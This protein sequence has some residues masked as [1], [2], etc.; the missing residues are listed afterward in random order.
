MAAIAVV[1]ASPAWPVD[2]MRSAVTHTRLFTRRDARRRRL[3]WVGAL[4]LAVV[5]AAVLVGVGV[6][7]GAAPVGAQA[8]ANTLSSIRVRDNAYSSGPAAYRY[9][10]IAPAFEPGTNAYTVTVPNAVD[11][12][13]IEVER[14]RS[15]TD[16][17][18]PSSTVGAQSVSVGSNAFTVGV[19]P[20]PGSGLVNNV[21]TVTVTRS[22]ANFDYD[23]DDDGLIDVRTLAQLNA[24]RYDLDGDGTAAL[25]GT[26]DSG[27][28]AAYDRAFWYPEAGLGCQGVDDDDDADTADV[29]VCRGYELRADLDFDTDGDGATYTLAADGTVSGDSG[30][31]Y[32]NGGAGWTPIADAGIG[33]TDFVATFEGNGHTIS[34]LFVNGGR[35]QS[36]ALGLFGY[37]G[38]S[39]ANARIRNLGLV[40]VF[41]KG[42]ATYTGGLAG[43]LNSNQTIGFGQSA[44]TAYG[45]I[46][47]SYVT[48]I[49][50]GAGNVGGLV[51]Q[52]EGSIRASYS[53]AAV[54][55]MAQAGG[56]VGQVGGGIIYNSY[57]AGP[58]AAATN[59]GGLAGFSSLNF[60]TPHGN[61]NVRSSYWDLE[62][63]CEHTRRA[64][65]SDHLIYGRGQTTAGLTTPTGYSGIYAAWDDLDVNDDGSDDDA[66]SF[67]A[68]RYPVLKIGGHDASAQADAQRIDYDCDDDGLIEI[69]RLAQLDVMRYDRDGSGAVDDGANSSSYAA[70]YPIAVAGMG[71]RLVGATNPAPVC[72]GYELG[73]NSDSVVALNFDTDGDDDVDASDSGGRYWNGGLGWEPIASTSTP[74][75]GTF[76]G[77]S[78]PVNRLF[79]NRSGAAGDYVGLFAAVGAGPSWLGGIRQEARLEG[80]RLVNASVTGR[81]YVGGLV[82]SGIGA[83]ADSS[84]SGAVSGGDYV[85]GLAG[86]VAGS[87]VNSYGGGSVS[88]VN[89]VGGLVGILGAGGSIAAAYAGSTV[90]GTDKV[91]GLAG[92]NQG[93]IAASY[94]MGAVTGATDVGGLAGAKSL[95]GAATDAYFDVETT[96]QAASPG[97]GIAQSTRALMEPTAYGTAPSIYREWDV[98]IDG[99][100]G[101]D[102]P[103]DFGTNRQYPVLK[104]GGHDTAG[105]FAL[106]PALPTD[107]A[108]SGLAVTDGDGGV[109]L[110]PAFSPDTLAYAA[111]VVATSSR[112]TVAAVARRSLAAVGYSVSDADGSTPDTFE[113]DLATGVNTFTITVT[114]AGGTPPAT[115]EYTLTITRAAGLAYSISSPAAGTALD[116]DGDAAART[117]T[118]GVSGNRAPPAAGDVLC[119]IAPNTAGGRAGTDASDFASLTAT[120]SFTASGAATDT[121]GSCVFTVSDDSDVESAEYFTVTLSAPAAN[122][123]AGA[124]YGAGRSFSIAASDALPDDATLSSLS[125]VNASTTAAVVLAPAFSAARTAYTAEVENGVTQVTV[126]ATSTDAIAGVAYEPAVDA[127]ATAPGHQVNVAVGG[128][129]IKAVVTAADG[130][131]AQEYVVALFRQGAGNTLRHLRVIGSDGNTY[132]LTPVFNPDTDT[133]DAAVPRRVSSVTIYAEGTNRGAGVQVDLN[134]VGADRTSDPIA[135]AI[136]ARKLIRIQ[137]TGAVGDGNKSYS[138]YVTRSSGIDYD[139]DDDGLID[140][141]NLAQLNAMR[142]DLD[143]DGTA[144]LSFSGDNDFAATYAG[145]FPSPLAGMGCRLADHD[146]DTTTAEQPTCRGYELRADLDFDTDDDGATWSRAADGT[147]TG[148]SGDAWYNGGAGWTPIGDVD[149]SLNPFITTFEGNGHTIS[150]LF[151]NEARSTSDAVGLFGFVG[152]LD[153][154]ARIRNVGLV[155]VLV[156]ETNAA[157]TGGLAGVLISEHTGSVSAAGFNIYGEI[158]ASYV[159]GSVSGAD[160]VGGLVGHSDGSIRASYSHAAVTGGDAVGGLVGQNGN[161]IV[162]NSYATGPVTGSSRA[163]GLTGHSTLNSQSPHQPSNVRNSYWDLRTSCQHTRHTGSEGSRT[164]GRGKTTAELTTLTGYTGIYA[165]W[166]ELD[167]N[168]DGSSDAA[169]QF[170][171]GRYPTLKIGG[172]DASAQASAQ[173]IDYDCDDDGLIEI[174]SLAGLNVTRYDLDGSGA[175]DSSA[176]AAAYAGQF[177]IAAATMGCALADHDG[178]AAT[179]PVRVCRGYELGANASASSTLLSLDFD[180]DGSGG[181]NAGD[182]YWNGGAGWTPIG[183][184]AQPWAAVFRGNQH[185]LSNLYI[186]RAAADTGLFGVVGASGRLEGV[187]L[188]DV[189][190]TSTMDDTGGLAG[191]N[192]GVISASGVTGTVSGG[193]N[194]GGL[195]GFGTGSIVGSYAKADVSGTV[196]V[197]GIVGASSGPVTAAYALGAVSGTRNVGGIAGSVTGDITASYA[198]GAVSGSSGVGALLGN[199]GGS[200]VITNGYYDSEIAGAMAGAGGTGYTRR[201]LQQPVA[202]RSGASV[203]ERIYVGWDVDLDNADG[204][205]NA[206]TG[207]DDPWDFGTNQQY[208]VLQY[209]GM[210]VAAQ[211]ALQPPLAGDTRLGSLVIT[212]TTSALTPAFDAG[213]TTY[214]LSPNPGS[215]YVTVAASPALSVTGVSIHPDDGQDGVPGHQVNLTRGVNTITV[216][217]TAQNRAGARYTVRF[218][219]AAAVDYDD[220]DDGLIDVRTLAQLDAIRYDRNGDGKRGAASALDWAKYTAAYPLAAAGMGCRRVD[221]DGAGPTPPAPVCTGYELRRGLDFDT[222]EA[223]VRTDDAYYNDGAGWT[224]IGGAAAAFTGAFQG[225]G[226]TIANLHINATGVGAVGLFGAAVNGTIEGVH[227]TGVDITASYTSSGQT[228]YDAGSLVGVMRGVTVRASSAVGTITATASGNAV[229]SV[230]GLAGRSISGA[231]G[232]SGS[233]IEASYAAVDVTLSSTSTANPTLNPDTAGGLVGTFS[234][235]SARPSFVTAAYALGDVAANRSGSLV[236]GLIGEGAGTVTASYATGTVT[237]STAAT[238]GLIGD[239]GS[240]TTVTASYWDSITSGVADDA[241]DPATAPEGKT[242]YELRTPT[243]YGTATSTP[244]SIY[245]GWDVDVDGETGGDDPWDFGTNQQYPVLKYGGH[246]VSAQFLLQPTIPSDNTLAALSVAPAVL[247]PGL[248]AATTTYA[249]IL[250][251]EA[252]AAVVTL[253]YTLNDAAA[254]STVSAIPGGGDAVTADADEDAAGYQVSV[255]AARTVITIAVTAP[256][257]AVREYAVTV[258]HAAAADYDRDDNGLIDVRTLAQLDAIRY[259]LDGD[260]RPNSGDWAPYTAAY[261]R[262]VPGMGCPSDTCTGYELVNA[263]DFD[264]GEAGDRTDDAY[265]NDGAGW[266]PI[267]HTQHS[268]Y[269]GDFQGNGHTIA[270]LYI[271]ST[272]LA[273]VGLFGRALH[274]NVSGLIEGVHLTGVDITASYTDNRVFPYH[275]VGALVG[276]IS[277]TVRGSSAVGEITTTAGGLVVSRV[278]GLVGI[279]FDGSVIANNYAAVDVTVSSTATATLV[280]RAGGL[281]GIVQGSPARS[282]ITASYALGDVAIN[283]AGARVGGLV[284]EI[285]SADVSASYATGTATGSTAATRGLT[286]HITGTNTPIIT[287]SYWDTTASGVADD[288]DDPAVAPEGKTVDE[289][290]TPTAYGTSTTTDIYVNWDVDVD[291]VAGVDDPWDF[292][293]AEQ[294]PVLQQGGHSIAAQHALQN[295]IAYDGDG[296]GLIDVATLAQLDAIRYDL[297]GDGKQGS[298]S[299]ADWAKYAAA[300]PRALPGMGC[301]SYTCT[302]YELVN[303]LDFDTGEAGVRTD[304]AYYND[305]AGW[306]P[307]G[308]SGLTGA[309]IG[310]FRGNGYAI[311]NLYINSS[312]VLGVGLFGGMID[313][314]IEGVHLTGVD[315]TTNYSSG[316]LIIHDVGGLAGSA[317]GTVRG[318]SVTGQIRTNAGGMAVSL[319]G[320]MVGSAV[321][322]SVFAN[323]YASVDV[324]VTSTS[325]ATLADQVGGLAGLLDG[326]LGRS[327]MTASYALGDVTASRAGARVGGLIGNMAIADVSA[328]YALGTVTGA[329]GATRGLIGGTGTNTAVTASYWDTSTTGVADDGDTAAPEGK[330]T[331]ELR[332]PTAYGVAT[333][334]PPSIYAGW[335][336]DVDGETGGDDPW[337]FGTNLEYP[338]LQFGGHDVAAQRALL[339]EVSTD[340]SLLALSVGPAVLSPSFTAATTT[341]AAMVPAESS[342]TAVLL[343]YTLGD[344]NASAAVSAQGPVGA[345]VTADADAHTPG[346]QVALSAAGD[347]VITIAVTAQDGSAGSYTVTVMAGAADYDDDE[348]GLIDVRTLAQ[349]DAIRY[350]LNGD[351]AVDSSANNAAYAAAFPRAASGMGC[352][353]EIDNHGMR[354]PPTCTGY[355]LRGSLLFNTGDAGIR[356]DDQYYNGGAGWT[357]IGTRAAPYTATFRGNGYR[358]ADLYINSNGVGWVGLFGVLDG[359]VIEGLGLVG[360]DITATHANS[361]TVTFLDVGAV[362]GRIAGGGTVRASSA[363]GVI[364]THASGSQLVSTAGGLV[365]TVFLD[366][367]VANSYA[368]VDVTVNSTGTITFPD[369]AGG[370]IGLMGGVQATRPTLTAGYATGAVKVSRGLAYAGGLVGS[371]HNGRVSASYATGRAADANG[372]AQPLIGAIQTRARISDSYWDSIASGAAD[373][374]DTTAPEGKT[375]AVLQG[376]TGY[377]TSTTT[378]IYVNWNVDV[379][380]ARGADDPWDFGTDQQYPVLQTGGHSIAA[381]RALLRRTTA[382]DGDGD[383]LIDVTSLA[384]LDAIRYDLNG[385]GRADRIA[386]IGAYAAGYPDAIPGMGCPSYTCTGYELVNGLDFDTGEAGDRTDD[387]YYRGGEGWRPIAGG[388][389][390]YYNAPA[391]RYSG[392]FNG[393]GHAIANLHIDVLLTGDANGNGA[394]AGLFGYVT[395]RVEQVALVNPEVKAVST[396]GAIAGRLG[397]GGSIVASYVQGGEI[398]GWNWLGGLV[399]VNNGTITASYTDVRVNSSS[400]T[401]PSRN[402]GAAGGLAGWNTGTIT[403]SYAMGSVERQEGAAVTAVTGGLTALGSVTGSEVVTDSYWDTIRT[404][405]STSRTAPA[406]AGKTTYELRTPTTYGASTTTDIYAGWNV[407]V[408]GVTGPD[409]PWNF[410]TNL[411]YPV[412]KYGGHDTAAQFGRQP[413]IASDNTLSALSVAP[414]VLSPSFAAGRT[415][416]TAALPVGSAA[417]AVTLAYTQNDAASSTAAV[418]AVAAGGAAVTADADA[419]APGYQVSVPARTVITIAVSTPDGAVRRYT[420]TIA[421]SA[422]ENDY[423]GNDNGLIDVRTLAQL[424]AIRY[425]LDGDGRASAGDLANYLAAFPNPV[426][427][428]GCPSGGCTGYELLNSLDFDTGEAGD[429]TDDAYYNDGAGWTPIAHTQH[430]AYIGDFQGNGHTIA[431]LYINS[432]GLA[433]VGLFGRALH[434]NVSGLIEG[435]HLTGVD[436]TASYTDNRVFPYHD[437]GALVGYISGTV[438][439]SSAVGEIRTTAGGQVVSRVGGLVGIAFDGSVIANNYAAVDVTVSSTATATLVDRAGGLVGIVQ[440]SPARSTITASYALGDVAINRAGARVGG[441]VGEISTSDVT[442]SY[443]TGTVTGSTAAT[444]GLTGHTAGTNP[445]VAD[446]YWDTTA[447]GVADDADDPAVAPEGKSIDELRAPTDYG[448]STTTDIYVNWNVDVDGVAGVD[449][450][451][452]FG[453]AEQYPVLKRGGHSIAAQ[454]ALQNVT[455][456][457]GDG[458]GLIDVATLAQLDAIRYDLNGDG[459]VADADEA[460]YAV[461]YPRA[462]VGMGCPSYT[463]TG[464]ELVNGLD[465]DTGEAGDRTDDAYYNDGAGW[466]PIGTVGAEY[467]ATFRGNGYGNAIAN[468]DIN[469]TGWGEAGLFGALSDGVIEGVHLTG[470]DIGASRTS[471]STQTY[472]RAGALSSYVARSTV[473]GSSAAGAITTTAGG[474]VISRVGGLVG[475]VTSSSSIVGSYA[476]VDVTVNSTTP[477]SSNIGDSDSAGGLAASL[478]GTASTRS[479]MTAVYATGDVAANRGGTFVGGLIGVAFQASVTAG[480]ATGTVTGPTTARTQG[481][482]NRLGTTATITDS[483]WDTSTTGVADDGDATA[484]EG[485]PTYELRTPTAYGTATSTPPSIYAG[486]DVDVDGETGGDDPWDFGTNLEYPVLQFGGHDVAAQR[487]LLPEV[488]TDATLT[489]LSVWPATL[490]PAFTAATTTYAAVVPADSTATAVL[491]A[492]TLGSANASAAVSAQGPVGAAVTADADAHTPGY[493]VALS[494]AGDTVITIT[495]T[496]QDGTANSYT[497]TV[498]AGVVDYDDDED[499]LIEVRTLA[500]LDA[501]RYDLNGDGAVSAGDASAYAAAFPRAEA[502]MGCRL[503]D[504]DDDA[505]T[506]DAPTCTGYELRSHLFFDTGDAGIRSDDRYYNGGAGWT[507]IG[508]TAAPYTATFRGRGNIIYDLFINSDGLDRV[509]LFGMV[510]GGVIAGLGL[511]GVSITTGYAGGSQPFHDVGAL[512]GYL[513][514]TLR[515][516]SATGAITVNGSGTA[517]SYAGGLVGSLENGVLANAYAAVAVTVNSTSTR[518]TPDRAGG[519]VG[520]LNGTA[521]NPAAVTAAYATGA[522]AAS[523]ANAQVGGLV[524][525]VLQA[526]VTASYATGRV[527]GST[528]ATRGLIGSIA[529]GGVITDSYWDSIR[530][531]AADDADDAAPEGKTPAA[532]RTPTAYG[533]ASG[534]DIYFGWNVDVDGEAGEDD[535]WDFGTDKQYPVLK[536]GWHSVSAQRAGQPVLSDVSTLAAL[537]VTPAAL[538]P[539]FT[540]SATAYTARLA[541]ET[542]GAVTVTATTTAIAAGVEPATVVITATD[543]GGNS[544]TADADENR[545]GH[546]VVIGTGINTITVKVTASDGSATTYTVIIAAAGVDFD[547]DEDG[548]IDVWTLAQLNAIRYD[549]NGDGTPAAGNTAAYQAAFARAAAGMG[550][551]SSGCTGYELRGPL[552][553]DTG[554]AGD[555]TDDDYYNGGAGWTPIGTEAAPFTAT[556]RGNGYANAIANL[557]IDSTGIDR[558]GLFGEVNGGLIE[559]V[560]LTGVDVAASYTS[561]ATLPYLYAGPLVGRFAGTVRGSSATGE[562]TTT[563]GGNVDS[564]VGGLVGSAGGNIVNS[565][566]AVDVTTNSTA[567][568]RRQSVGGLVGAFFSSGTRTTLAAAYATG[569]VSANRVG[570]L[571]TGIWVGGLIGATTFANVTAN[572][573][574]GTVAGGEA[575][576]GLI[577]S[578]TGG[579]GNHSVI[580]DSYWDSITSGVADDADTTAPEGKPPYE[581]RGPTAYGTTGIYANWNVDVDGVTGADDPWNFGTNLQY[582]VLKQGGH[583]IAAQQALQP[584]LATGN[585]LAARPTFAPALTAVWTPAF[586]A[587]SGG[588]YQVELSAADAGTHTVTATAVVGATVTFTS[589]DADTGTDGHQITAASGRDTLMLTVTSADGRAMAYTFHLDIGTP[590]AVASNRVVAA[591]AAA[592]LDGSGSSDPAGQTLSYAWTQTGANAVTEAVSLSSSTAASPTFTAPSPG[593]GTLTLH[594]QLTVTDPDGLTD[595]ATAQVTVQNPPVVNR[596]TIVSTAPGG[597]YG[598]GETITA[599]VRFNENVTVTGTPQLAI[600]IGSVTRQAGYASGSGGNTLRFSYTA[601]ASDTDADGITIAANALSL[602]G[603]AIRSAADGLDARLGLGSHAL[604]TAQASHKVDGGLT[605]APTANAGDDD[606]AAAG[607]TVT[608][609]ASSSS[610]PQGSRLTYAWAQTGATLST[611]RVTLSNAAAVRPTFTAPSITGRDVILEFTVTV[612]DPDGNTG[613]D[614]VAITVTRRATVSGVSITSTPTGPPAGIYRVGETIAAAV[615]FS[616]NV[617]VTGNPQLAITG[618]S[619]TFMAS[620]ATAGSS[621]DTLRFTYTVTASDTDADGISIA[622]N[623][624]SL[625]GGAIKDAATLDAALGLGSSAIT[626][627]G[628]H[629]VDG[630]SDASRPTANAGDDDVVAAGTPGIT[631]D[632]SGSTGQSL[633]YLWAQTGG[634]LANNPVTLS[635]VTA[636]QPTFT[637]PAI[638]AGGSDIALEFRVTVTDTAGYTA[639]DTVTVTVTRRAEVSGVSITSTPAGPPAGVYRTGATIAVSVQF[640]EN[641]TVTGVP[642]LAITGGSGVFTANYDAISSTASTLRFAYTVRAG[643]TDADGIS[644]AANA[645]TLNGGKIADAPGLAA[646]LGLGS[647]AIANAASH[648]VDGSPYTAPVVSAVSILSSPQSGD[649]YGQGEYIKA[650]VTFSKPITVTGNPQL[651]IIIGSAADVRTAA[652]TGTAGN[653]ATLT[654]GYTVQASDTDSDGISI[655]ANALSRNGG[656]IRD[657]SSLDAALSLGSN[658]I[659]NAG[660]HKVDG[661][662]VAAPTVRGVSILSTPASGDTYGAGETILVSIDFGHSMAATG[663]PQLAIGIGA[664]TEAAGY[665]EIAGSSLIFEYEVQLADRDND[666]ITIGAS[667]LTLNG[668]A[669]GGV[670]GS[671]A[672]LGLGSHALATA[673]AAHKVNGSLQIAPTVA[674]ITIESAPLIGNTYGRGETIIVEVDFSKTVTVTGNPQL[675]LTGNGGAQYVARYVSVSGNTVVFTYAIGS[676]DRDGNGVSIAANAMRRNGGAIRSDAGSLEANLTHRPVSADAY[677]RVDGRIDRVGTLFT[678]TSHNPAAP[679]NVIVFVP[680]PPLP[681]P[682][683]VLFDTAGSIPMNAAR[684]ALGAAA[685][686]T[687]V[688]IT[689]SGAKAGGVEVCLP[690]QTALRSVA[691]AEGKPLQVLRYNGRVWEAMAGSRDFDSHICAAGV[692]GFSAFAAGYGQSQPPPPVVSDGG[693]GGG[694]FE[695]A[696][697]PTPT[698]TPAPAATPTVAPTPGTTVV[699]TATPMPTRVPAGTP[700]PTPS[701]TLMPTPTA[702]AAPTP[703]VSA[704]PTTAPA[705]IAPTATPTPAPAARAAT[706][707]PMPTT[708]PAAPS[709]ALPTPGPAQPL[710]PPPSP[711]SPDPGG[712]SGLDVA[713]IAA[714]VLMA[715]VIAAAIVLRRRQRQR[716][717]PPEEA[718]IEPDGIC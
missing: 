705:A 596:V 18:S 316:T 95:T 245:A 508:T 45:E 462:I 480:Y 260:G 270:N 170:T 14:S 55:G 163:G 288:A 445:T 423:D 5:A 139:D 558:V 460:A 134:P 51:G 560:A 49:V 54:S 192:R 115:A 331:Y 17:L 73:A 83:I 561:T 458:D 399:G 65:S 657:A 98:D 579:T 205:N 696:D 396:V 365:G 7:D 305:G 545:P 360:V 668:G 509:G 522:V 641:V 433:W 155:N 110:T 334:T 625:N 691:E 131:T 500:Q 113:V 359:G 580:T 501:I 505:N 640:S 469:P 435:V 491:L 434:D 324:T 544:V 42:T 577:G 553:F 280:D 353:R 250:P 425:D 254:T 551:P 195:A 554:E 621:A 153:A 504:H 686:S 167:V 297:N 183:S 394:Y 618:G 286:G 533:T 230:G 77:N 557:M 516:S 168:G 347:T 289:L 525:R 345:A 671:A 107:A 358:I 81:N 531:G 66:W 277:G 306:T 613:A 405:Q 632:A 301:P 490:S 372:A 670:N 285:A 610:D 483:Y 692:S 448:T 403:A 566:A 68:G 101:D 384:Q 507:P 594:F 679:P 620:Y 25:S 654:F 436:I 662:V 523:R 567:L 174:T 547:D 133:Y 615:Q 602:N 697:A 228:A 569:D 271:N 428:M 156:Q 171:A 11:T 235:N 575:A 635:S 638:A 587:S 351:G 212:D 275:D 263:L 681:T 30:D 702:A 94:A 453:T 74:F 350:D 184:A 486:W 393:N 643:D 130:V 489:A 162:H 175:A 207:G 349:L 61:S 296:D 631:L 529:A 471:T 699:P 530:S 298:V 314:P 85:G 488:A 38:K 239:I 47:T 690:A 165:A 172:H 1:I 52:N 154:S 653:T 28:A 151:I 562:I 660:S 225:N 518:L 468:L 262:A 320:G 22:A 537:S 129:T 292:G 397:A 152:K 249:A 96:G 344:A 53:H 46:A 63:S 624:L 10:D 478:A 381:Q 269:I 210:S 176:N 706:P 79:I 510:D 368:A 710:P 93:G 689:V 223:G 221:P 389:D 104:Q 387:E 599:A 109:T 227:L 62:T 179:A 234:S 33:T 295:I 648:K 366:G 304:D 141:R 169:W 310:D 198:I 608:L 27:F 23:D 362:T 258:T 513:S 419:V 647:N 272:G 36:T 244:P 461:G 256:D 97:G 16:T 251:A 159:T 678:S 707:A 494:S 69:T 589:A 520:L 138:L 222:G 521:S 534:T 467:T 614:T 451:W 186:N 135:L 116:E 282:T 127:D 524:G 208:P 607:A 715:V 136:G 555:R 473:R 255:S 661:S 646:A 217:V 388:T 527:T 502:G 377:G 363:T 35:S 201:E 278:G 413:V 321:G 482:L 41:V 487:A 121:A 601:A 616:E 597:T 440:G 655:A 371:I 470:V 506:A 3:W 108:L 695:D 576:Q 543:A 404:G 348:D 493:Q 160:H 118:V 274:D 86:S 700:A 294:Y 539:N 376:P 651:N 281:V 463:C 106:Q 574:T 317:Y 383:G 515:G 88:G 519:L 117:L 211:R 72:T 248:S 237:G 34:N 60:V 346:Y 658:A 188:T 549:L 219:S 704:P 634:T 91:G 43:Y 357:P 82:G 327:S 630:R 253:E 416:Y 261:P 511:S 627:A 430:S 595:T 323:N 70:G 665:R 626:N 503:T 145:A 713:L 8:A 140:V 680:N 390:S 455:A 287:D 666:G 532:L 361:V 649:T 716:Q 565:Y 279:A 236:G 87:V 312:N 311:A 332:T 39:D 59:P 226:Q 548:L 391:V 464:Y 414:A 685:A 338:V 37:V 675:M 395:G 442:A 44:F 652:L 128:N 12:V 102:D 459:R 231:S 257:G 241:D 374:G 364:T 329:G 268:A 300:Y 99:V 302:G 629:Q 581:L 609:D 479:A 373:D 664:G 303:G 410:G 418:V 550:C 592:S 319:V 89:Y 598:G 6:W 215:S 446:S 122:A 492:Y 240:N 232:Q 206:A 454:H 703:A 628:S 378:D 623:A 663:T 220:D 202:Y 712:L 20:P 498:T 709:G 233:R 342:A 132:P 182:A 605:R 535:P 293:T 375:P 593:S 158:S 417:A 650:Q 370:L 457:D 157:Y 2:L 204:D 571:Q 19:V 617:T 119:T 193:R 352:R 283:R 246:S 687:V 299:D 379:D 354:G 143:G 622:A 185:P 67:T 194:A 367:H 714:A 456:Y 200:A 137:V 238:R 124:G 432:T 308:E 600:R 484:P 541:A 58:V 146:G 181:A 26:G 538:A 639:T 40:D 677:Q 100:S 659:A 406:S 398:E 476:A 424:D 125:I 380:G 437:V 164:Y 199:R 392:V 450:P 645:L 313:G 701:P 180:S 578:N 150:N 688:D 290:R 421:V 485:K 556:F 420:V 573:A 718:E 355:E 335:D 142:Y 401:L 694:T 528:A 325:T 572:Y 247:S 266:T 674:G 76:K 340:T 481:L 307:I 667:A 178:D 474:T 563:T 336:V 672:T 50:S 103:W 693:N 475:T 177:P 322:G 71:C 252:G 80:V 161:G 197:G 92:Y 564:H 341:Y 126:T 189:S 583:S 218:N 495:V 330:P 606:V 21:Y 449:D 708:L 84:V 214:T 512:A 369:R 422:T 24:I 415:D 31:A 78:N 568:G 273:W 429:R 112:V 465:F 669:I 656:S 604:T 13:R 676:S 552:D 438:R 276:Y 315:I 326:F 586:D 536:R 526:G 385:D 431:N 684:L 636:A 382:Y 242:T 585:R 147:I 196:G 318:S 409:D 402:N 591:G 683:S 717:R 343:A 191:D 452:D 711:E 570:T 259:D 309:Y 209:G 229:S 149:S 90:S 408:D 444:R 264:T 496:A 514:G 337:D 407:D 190:V 400:L 540:P 328:S 542:V 559:G 611:H 333:S 619:G 173:R 56:L 265:Y 673:Q 4:L 187:I 612:T 637:A 698:A 243:A 120:A 9:F 144:A 466:T 497:V 203:E 284:G 148:D 499:G 111:S 644:I 427:G 114:A 216:H 633:T 443:A 291:G 57:A 472:L 682:F 447:S 64:N 411:Q 213:V 590:T 29:P 642:Q 412:L 441:L 15:G 439:G 426:A 517:I 123:I 339:P 603:G 386:D 588:P 32:Y 224:P 356:S 166:D 584:T 582:P 75:I 267:A 48:G 477:A 546:Q 105:Q